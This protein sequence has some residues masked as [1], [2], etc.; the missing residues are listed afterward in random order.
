MPT[1]AAITVSQL[2]RRAKTLLEK[3]LA[4]LWVEGEISNM[5]RPAS[6]LSLIH[7]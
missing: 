1:E 6:G 4:R 7:N 5:A 3:G 2:N